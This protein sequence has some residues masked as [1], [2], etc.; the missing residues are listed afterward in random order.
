MFVLFYTVLSLSSTAQKVDQFNTWLYYVG[1]YKVSNKLNAQVAYAWCRND[2]IKYWQLS[3]LQIGVIRK[4]LKKVSF[5]AGYEWVIIYPYGAFPLL[6]PRTEHRIFEQFEIKKKQA[7]TTFKFGGKLEQRF[8]NKKLKHRIQLNFTLKVPVLACT[9][10]QLNLGITISNN[11]FFNGGKT[12]TLFNQNRAYFG[13]DMRIKKSIV[14]RAGYMN[15]Y[16]LISKNKIE[17]N[18]TLVLGLIHKLNFEN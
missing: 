4:V 16:L 11:F 18:H 6:A 5:G 15:Q 9:S 10:Q 3:K 13:I 8:Y 12:N 2:F 1:N 17:N 7:R 14:L